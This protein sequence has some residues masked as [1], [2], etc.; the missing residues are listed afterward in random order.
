MIKLLV[1]FRQDTQSAEFARRYEKNIALLR[2]MPG[3]QRIQRG[4]VAGNPAGNP[5]YH[6]M[7]EVYFESF[8][9]LDAALTSPEGVAAGKDLMDFAGTGAEML[10][11]EE[12]SGQAKPLTPDN[13]QAYL[14][15]FD[16]EAEIVYP[17]QPTPTVPAAAEA[18]GVAEDHIVKSVV[19]LVSERP[20]VVYANGTRKVDPRKLADRLNVSRKQVKLADA[21]E[22]L[23]LTGYVVGTVPPVGLKTQMPA[24]LDPAIQ[25][26]EVVYAGGGGI[27]AL[28]RIAPAEL[29]RVSNAEI[30]AMLREE[31]TPAAEDVSPEDE[32]EA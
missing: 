10:F 25:A 19:F 6:H 11:V 16:I 24:F 1:L 31:D 2:R 18:L 9:A 15:N 12:Q 14:D 28:L 8:E 29:L 32:S 30:A 21:D 26:F 3:V 5:A 27:S 13:L 4:V 17:G 23:D 20:F 22:V 7:S